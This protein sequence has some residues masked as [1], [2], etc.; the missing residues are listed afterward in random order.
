MR[1]VVRLTES[2]LIRIVKK[3][4]R[5]NEGENEYYQ[6]AYDV[7]EDISPLAGP[8]ILAPMAKLV[9]EKLMAD[10]DLDIFYTYLQTLRGGSFYD[11]EIRGN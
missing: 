11:Y 3:V 2:D 8:K 6:S 7:L 10:E 9:S 5:E 4:I 1:K